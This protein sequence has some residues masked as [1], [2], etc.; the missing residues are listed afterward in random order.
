G[1]VDPP[2]DH[3][4]R[5]AYGQPRLPLQR[6]AARLPPAGGA[7]L[8]PDDRDGDPRP[9]RRS[10]GRRRAVPVRRTDR[11]RTAGTDRRG[12]PRPAQGHRRVDRA[13][14]TPV[15]RAAATPV[16]RAAATPIDARKGPT[17]MI[18]VTFKGLWAHRR[19][20]VGM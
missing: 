9:C 17:T 18:T 10:G 15:D 6:R 13:A 3:L 2:G 4:R 8:R 20:L 14:A 12:G 16:D 7:V 19:R 5:R 1:P 11:R